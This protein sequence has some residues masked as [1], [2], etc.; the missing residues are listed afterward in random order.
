[1]WET[2]AEH[3]FTFISAHLRDLSGE[4]PEDL[5]GRARWEL[6]LPDDTDEANWTGYRARVAALRPIRDFIFPHRDVEGQRHFSRING[7]PYF[8]S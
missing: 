2:D 4:R 1:M 6:R 8:D 5:L 3:R 7:K